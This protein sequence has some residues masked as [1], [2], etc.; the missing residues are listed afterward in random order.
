M[1]I[2]ITILCLTG[3][4]V[5]TD[6]LLGLL[7]SRYREKAGQY[8]GALAYIILLA[9]LSYVAYH[10][11]ADMIVFR[12]FLVSSQ[13]IGAIF[14]IGYAINTYRT[15]HQMHDFQ[16][17]CELHEKLQ[18]D[19]GHLSE[20][21]NRS[22]AEIAR[23]ESSLK[24]Y[25]QKERIAMEKH[26]LR[27]ISNEEYEERLADEEAVDD[28]RGAFQLYALLTS[29]YSMER[30]PKFEIRLH[31]VCER[32]C[33]QLSEED[34]RTLLQIDSELTRESGEYFDATNAFNQNKKDV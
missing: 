21:H 25:L 24:H 2:N 23:L 31:N 14:V 19:Y 10:A 28:T 7:S 33:S 3:T 6:F 8:I 12:D 30:G 22:L 32:I 11:D 15:V 4:I 16:S 1:N 9:N 18:E 27:I 17:V 29:G 20:E 26:N 34:M 5:L 13:L